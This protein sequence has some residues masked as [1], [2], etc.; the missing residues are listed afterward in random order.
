MRFSELAGKEIIS[1]D[2]GARLG[3]ID[4]TD[5]VIDT[6]SGQIRSLLI[7]NR[8]SFF[9]RRTLVLG[10]SGIEKVGHDFVIVNLSDMESE[11]ESLRRAGID[12]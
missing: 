8:G 2:E 7:R 11:A 10:W 5:L 1:I 12:V 6:E 9:K 3:V 4:D